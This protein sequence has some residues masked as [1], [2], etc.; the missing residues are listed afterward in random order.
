M[1]T[2]TILLIGARGFLGSKVLDAVLGKKKYSVK[3]L[4]RE[5]SD[6]SKI[7][8]QGVDVVRGDM[9]DSASLE[10]AFVGVD[11]VINTANG[12]M[13]G[14]PEID[15]EGA[16]N[17]VDAVKKI[18]VKRYI[19]CGVLTAEKAED[20][21]HFR[22]KALAEEYMKSQEVPFI[23]L[24]PGGFLDQSTDYLG[25]GIKRGDSFAICPWNKTVPVGMIH[26]ADLAQF[27]ADAIELPPE[28]DRT[29]IDVGWSRPIPYQEVVSIAAAKLE[30]KMSCYGLPWFVRVSLL[31]T[32]GVFRP[33]ERE[34]LKMFDFFDTGEYVNDTT[35]QEKHF[36]KP[37]TPEEV[38]G[39]YVDKLVDNSQAE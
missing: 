35:S 28:A 26:T 27:F 3:A 6:A 38:I 17:V 30:R 23:S 10:K 33:L 11:V 7:E 25:D 15:I 20:V 9:M 19:F 4:I 18:G 5:G 36:G 37:P 39:R 21:D 1:T 32:I 8:A 22:N 31:Y 29:A 14:H 13:Q 24:R 2:K 16:N 34:M 12:Y